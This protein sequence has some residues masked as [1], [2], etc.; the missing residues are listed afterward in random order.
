MI[1]TVPTSCF[2]L[3]PHTQC[4]DEEVQDRRSKVCFACEGARKRIIFRSHRA[5]PAHTFPLSRL[6]R[7]ARTRTRRQRMQSGFKWMCRQ[8]GACPTAGLAGLPPSRRRLSSSAWVLT[9]KLPSSSPLRRTT[10]DIKQPFLNSSERHEE[11]LIVQSITKLP[12][13]TSGSSV[14][15]TLTQ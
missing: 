7:N 6:S 5:V 2:I 14:E 15:K 11:T 8:I 4:M 13:D 3:L 10:P 12:A 1:A 9:P